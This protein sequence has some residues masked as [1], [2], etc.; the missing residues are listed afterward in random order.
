MNIFRLA[1]DM[2]HLLSIIVLLLKI[3]TIKSCAGISLKTQELYAL[4]FV[5]RYL[6]I[7]TSYIS[8][9]NTIMKLIFLG[10]AFS[11]VW[12]MR[13]HKVVK[14]TYDKHQ[15]TFRHYYLAL[16]C[17]ALALV[18]NHKFTVREKLSLETKANNHRYKV[19][20]A[21]GAELE[22]WNVLWTFSIYLEAVAILPQLVLLQR[23]KNVDNLTGNYVFLLGAYR[24]LYLLNWI[25]RYFTEKHYRQWITWISGIVQTALYADFFYYYVISWKNNQRLQLPA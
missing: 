17:L 1:G 10:S 3:H 18:I 14:Q 19:Y 7:F 21:S 13:F 11:I 5:T 4:V 22:T 24:G 8:F 2:T 25:V 6:D 16:G 23:T 12:Y 20:L 9:Y 15:D